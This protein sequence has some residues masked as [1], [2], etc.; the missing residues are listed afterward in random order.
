MIFVEDFHFHNKV[1]AFREFITKG[2]GGWGGIGSRDGAMVGALTSRHCDLCSVLGINVTC[3]F[4]FL[5][6]EG[7]LAVLQFSSIHKYQPRETVD[8]VQS[9]KFQFIHLLFNLH[10]TTCI[11]SMV[12]CN[13][14]CNCPNCAKVVYFWFFKI[15]HVKY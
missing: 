8:K 3:W 10:W 1:G 11:S 15:E 14:T 6:R 4:L 12:W 5:P 2:I 13:L 9:L 7:F